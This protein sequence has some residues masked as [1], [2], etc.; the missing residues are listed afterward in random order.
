MTDLLNALESAMKSDERCVC[1]CV[2]VCVHMY[3]CVSVR[4]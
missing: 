2:C 1:V 3:M 4:V